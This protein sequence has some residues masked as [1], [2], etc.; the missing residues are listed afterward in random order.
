[1]ELHAFAKG[2]VHHVGDVTATLREWQEIHARHFLA[3]GADVESVDRLSDS[4]AY[5]GRPRIPIG[6]FHAIGILKC[7]LTSGNHIKVRHSSTAWSIF[8]ATPSSRREPKWTATLVFQP[9]QLLGIG[10]GRSRLRHPEPGSVSSLQAQA[11]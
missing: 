8:T 5:G 11:S 6:L 1:M 3:E 2:V 4:S 7:S 10:K 9:W